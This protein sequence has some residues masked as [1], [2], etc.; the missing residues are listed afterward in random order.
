MK[1]TKLAGRSR[2]L[3]AEILEGRH[4]LSACGVECGVLDGQLN[5]W[6]TPQSDS[7]AVQYEARSSLIRVFGGEGEFL[8][9]YPAA[10][11]SN[12]YVDGLS[13]DDRLHI[14][15][16][17]PIALRV[18]GGEGEDTLV[19]G[20]VADHSSHEHEAAVIFNVERFGS[21][22]S[23]S[24]AVADSIAAALPAA[25]A[26][27]AA[28]EHSSHGAAAAVTAAQHDHLTLTS[29]DAGDL[30]SLAG[31]LHSH[32]GAISAESHL[33]GHP[34]WAAGQF[35]VVSTAVAAEV[36]GLDAKSHARHDVGG[37][38]GELSSKV[39]PKRCTTTYVGRDLNRSIY[40]QRQC[41]CEAKAAAKEAARRDGETDAAESQAPAANCL[42]CQKGAIG[43]SELEF[44]MMG[45]EVTLEDVLAAL[46]DPIIREPPPEA[47]EG[48]PAGDGSLAGALQIAG[49][50]LLAAGATLLPFL[51]KPRRPDS[52]VID[53]VMALE[54][55]WS[56]G[57]KAI[58]CAA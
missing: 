45:M 38:S 16:Q 1:P 26:L 49:Y 54:N 30:S 19:S 5:I 42:P 55:D 52:Q 33:A 4:V 6:G 9:Q 32:A 17:L 22:P 56:T 10:S 37:V 25:A 36:G 47:A 27:L 31:G 53:E 12:I 3:Y 2:H 46:D 29:M 44:C 8:G 23:S 40:G 39:T 43:G 14:D 18:N 34:A 57:C 24:S 51:W 58:P 13:G 28:G 48:S 21:L 41:D 7:I 15:S 50:A 11:I 20:L 35:S